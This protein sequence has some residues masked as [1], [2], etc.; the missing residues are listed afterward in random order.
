MLEKYIELFSAAA[1]ILQAIQSRQPRP[2]DLASNSL[3]MIFRSKRSI[4]GQTWI[5]STEADICLIIHKGYPLD[6][7]YTIEVSTYKPRRVLNRLNRQ[8]KPLT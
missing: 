1:L 3:P 2:I 6:R 8:E 5:H 4:Y 7:K